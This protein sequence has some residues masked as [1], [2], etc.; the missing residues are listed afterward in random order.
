MKLKLKSKTS[1][2]VKNRLKRKV[3]IRKKVSGTSERPRLCVYKSGRHMYAQLV[4]DVSGKTIAAVSS[5]KK[6]AKKGTEMAK[7]V[8]AEIAKAA[9]D[10]KIDSVVFDRSGFIYHGRVKALADS[11]RE[12]GLKF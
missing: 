4:D 7:E 6:S 1:T 10:K 9:L 2:S 12:A 11:A 5:L 8:G 3:R